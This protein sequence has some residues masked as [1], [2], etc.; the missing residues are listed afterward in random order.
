MWQMSI[1]YTAPGFDL[2]TFWY[3]SPSLTTRPGP[4]LIESHFTAVIVL[5]QGLLRFRFNASQ[6]RKLITFAE[7]SL[8]LPSYVYLGLNEREVGSYVIAKF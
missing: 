7:A 8:Y 4:P 5:V 1:H 3:E 6:I 2:T